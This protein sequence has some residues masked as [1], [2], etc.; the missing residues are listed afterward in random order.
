MSKS[1][2]IAVLFCLSGFCLSGL[3]QAAERVPAFM[4][5]EVLKAA[6][7]IGLTETQQPLFRTAVGTFV[8]QRMKAI[9]KLMRKHNQTG[10]QRKI[11]SKTNSLLR[12]MDKSMAEFLEDEQ[13]PAYENYRDKLKANLWGM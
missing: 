3:A 1:V 12:D 9:N 8:D 13:M 11:K 5:P 10:L 4:Q 2:L 7:G 6:A